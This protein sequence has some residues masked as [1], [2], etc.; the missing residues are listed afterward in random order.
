LDKDVLLY[1]RSRNDLRAWLYNAAAA[2]DFAIS[3]VDYS[4][5]KIDGA[6]C[7]RVV[8]KSQIKMFLLLKRLRAED[9]RNLEGQ[10][11]RFKKSF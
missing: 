6:L 3:P 7:L 2:L 11:R 8:R 4:R 1:F 9:A 10:L 5:D